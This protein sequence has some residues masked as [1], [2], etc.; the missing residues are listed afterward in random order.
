M[1]SEIHECHACAAILVFECLVWITVDVI[2]RHFFHSIFTTW[3]LIN[4]H[5]NGTSLSK[6]NFYTLFHNNIHILTQKITQYLFLIFFMENDFQTQT[7]APPKNHIKIFK[8]QKLNATS[9]TPIQY[10]T[11]HQYTPFTKYLCLLRYGNISTFTTHFFHTSKFDLFD[12]RNPKIQNWQIPSSRIIPNLK[13]TKRAQKSP[14]Q[15][16]SWPWNCCTHTFGRHCLWVL[17]F[18]SHWFGSFE[19]LSCNPPQVT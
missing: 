11:F 19:P 6:W 4:T 3:E 16:S 7:L 9:Q 1:V 13:W 10:T 14:N 8:N 18:G 12:L 5:P 17:W 2:R 15:S